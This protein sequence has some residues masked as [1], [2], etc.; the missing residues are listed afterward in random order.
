MDSELEQEEVPTE[1]SPPDEVPTEEPPNDETPTDGSPPDAVPTE[2]SLTDEAPTETTPTDDV[3]VEELSTADVLAEEAS[4]EEAPAEAVPGVDPDGALEPTPLETVTADTV[5][6]LNEIQQFFM[7]LLQPYRLTQV[8]IILLLVLISLVISRF[9]T[10]GF[11]QWLRSREGMPLWQMR[12]LAICNRRWHAIIFVAL[13]WLT[14]GIMQQV[15][16]PSRSYLIAALATLTTAWLVISIAGRLIRNRSLRKLTV[17]FAWIVVTLQILGLWDYFYSLLDAV[18]INFGATRISLLVVVQVVMAI[19]VFLF[20]A[21]VLSRTAAKR[22]N[23]NED[24]SPSLKVLSI[25]LTKLGLYGVAFVLGVQA[26]GFDLTTL[27]VLSG[28]IGLGL[29]FGL[30]KIVSNLVSGVIL[31][32]DKSIKPGD[33]ISLDDT[34]GWISDLGARYAAVVTRD[35]RE[36]LIPNEDLITR[37]VVNWSHSNQLVRLEI[38]FGV[39]YDSDPHLVRRISVECLKGVGRVR[40]EPR[41]VCH[42]TAFGESS[43]DYVLRFWISDP[44]RGLANVRGNV[45]LALWDVLKENEIDIPYPRRDI[46]FVENVSESGQ[47]ASTTTTIE[48]HSVN[49]NSDV[50][51]HDGSNEDDGKSERDSETLGLEELVRGNRRHGGQ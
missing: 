49:E 15:T 25:K 30:Q 10:R 36:Y 1:G 50:V 47:P 9:A 22:I 51:T 8:G 29:G 35:G 28:A 40:S 21:N 39:S 48:G 19:A 24:I 43:V 6:L 33:V 31:L 2:E 26:V 46:Q 3:P 4:T 44:S 42:I 32:M 34:F 23:Q 38:N 18:A 5:T 12:F 11:T 16:W 13:I 37:Q 20:L 14:V 17:G 27:T 7:G 41:P 45:F